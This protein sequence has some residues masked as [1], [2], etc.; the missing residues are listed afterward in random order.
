MNKKYT[1]DEICGLFYFHYFRVVKETYISKDGERYNKAKKDPKMMLAFE[2]VTVLIN[3]HG[4]DADEYITS[5]FTHHKKYVH[6][7][8]LINLSTL[9]RYKHELEDRQDSDRV[10][11]IYN[12]L[13]KSIR[14]VAI[15][16]KSNDIENVTGFFR[17]CKQYDTLGV[18]LMSGKISKYYLSMFNNIERIAK[19][20]NSDT[21]DE[22]NT[23]VVNHR[24]QLNQDARKAIMRF[25]GSKRVS[26]IEI[27]NHNINKVIGE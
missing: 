5:M 20:M 22:I 7:K 11:Y 18:Y 24:D 13:I 21:C 4:I 14:F 12:Q 2:K 9:S 19:L 15:H 27:T 16:C 17:Y 3:D 1:V 8:V 26:I 23:N 6:P 25:T 10:T